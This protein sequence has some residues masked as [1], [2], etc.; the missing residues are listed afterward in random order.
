M[1]D[2]CAEIRRRIGLE[3]DHTQERLPESAEW[4]QYPAGLPVLKGDPLFPRLK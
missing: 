4:G 1:P 2:A 3:E